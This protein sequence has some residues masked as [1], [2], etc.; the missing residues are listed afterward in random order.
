MADTKMAIT[1]PVPI[2]QTSVE[3]VALELVMQIR[4]FEPD[5]SATTA[6]EY[7]LKLYAECLHVVKYGHPES[8]S[9]GS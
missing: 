1:E 2:K 5:P 4:R 7:F 8:A 9:Q 3:S 6:R